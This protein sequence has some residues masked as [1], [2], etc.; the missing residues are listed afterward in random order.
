VKLGLVLEAIAEKEGLT[1]TQDDLNAEI[2]RLA[3]ELKM[4]A[5]DLVKMVKAGG[6]ESIDELRARIL[7][8]KALDFVYRN[9]VIQG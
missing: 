8:G 5:A 7:D 4:P 1:V 9:A 6:Q 3:A 2:I